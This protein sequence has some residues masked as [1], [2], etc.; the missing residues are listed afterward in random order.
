MVDYVNLAMIIEMKLGCFQR[1]YKLGV[2]YWLIEDKNLYAINLKTV[3]IAL[4][5]Y[6]FNVKMDITQDK[7][8]RIHV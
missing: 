5:M 1:D 4:K 8:R 3:L 2:K 7:I 6:A